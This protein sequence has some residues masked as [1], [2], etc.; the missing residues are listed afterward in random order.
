[1]EIKIGKV[2]LGLT[3]NGTPKV[4]I[5]PEDADFNNTSEAIE[6]IGELESLYAS[7]RKK[8][9]TVELIE[10][11]KWKNLKINDEYIK[12]YNSQAYDRV[13]NL[14][15]VSLIALNKSLN[16][17]RTQLDIDT[18]KIL[19]TDDLELFLKFQDETLKVLKDSNTEYSKEVIKNLKLP[20]CEQTLNP[21]QELNKLT[22]QSINNIS[23]EYKII[24]N[25]EEVKAKNKISK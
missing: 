19:L 1:M 6:V 21:Y 9:E 18:A 5:F 3:A 10:K 22:L 17:N 25:C 7:T 2:E 4:Y 15:K 12:A 8:G 24:N 16:G 13:K 14:F 23:K 20:M 11:G